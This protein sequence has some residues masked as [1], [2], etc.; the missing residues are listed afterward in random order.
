MS[1]FSSQ[2]SRHLLNRPPPDIGS[3][4]R[5]GPIGD[6]ARQRFGYP[7]AQHFVP[8]DHLPEVNDDG[9]GQEGAYDRGVPSALFGDDDGG[10][11]LTRRDLGLDVLG[12][13][14]GCD[15][16]NPKCRAEVSS[17]CKFS[18]GDLSMVAGIFSVNGPTIF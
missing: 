2:S 7:K 16:V 13:K 18:G 1:S 10:R 9:K 17:V 4:N 14:I 11:L 5:P 8:D 15:T 3:N 12:G 6:H